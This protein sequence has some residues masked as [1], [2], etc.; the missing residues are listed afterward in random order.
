MFYGY[1][2]LLVQLLFVYSIFEVSQIT[3]KDTLCYDSIK[4]YDKKK[5]SDRDFL[6]I[7]NAFILIFIFVP[8]IIF[9][10]RVI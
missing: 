9:V 8:K 10:C 3:I 5:A 2:I 6:T 4:I 7:L 1:T